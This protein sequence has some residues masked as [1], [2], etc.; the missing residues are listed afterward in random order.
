MQRILNAVVFR[1]SATAIFKIATESAESFIPVGLNGKIL[2]EKD[3]Y[4]LI[5]FGTHALMS[6]YN[7]NRGILSA[8]LSVSVR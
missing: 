7:Q 3:D 8:V 4:V 5:D 1:R 2:Q 6:S